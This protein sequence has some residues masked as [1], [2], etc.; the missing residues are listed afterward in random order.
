MRST[1]VFRS[2][3]I[4]WWSFTLPVD[5]HDATS[6]DDENAGS[7]AR[8]DYQNSVALFEHEIKH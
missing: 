2:F 1:S 4:R 8:R 3:L 7:Q 6:R 5:E